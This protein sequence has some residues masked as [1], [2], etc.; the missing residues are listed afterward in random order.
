MSLWELLKVSYRSISILFPWDLNN[1][2][3]IYFCCLKID[4]GYMHQ[5]QHLLIGIECKLSAWTFSV[6]DDGTQKR[7]FYSV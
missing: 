1:P 2:I 7:N 5:A 3:S 4:V 6:L